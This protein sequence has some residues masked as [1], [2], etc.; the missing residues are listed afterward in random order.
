MTFK[1]FAWFETDEAVCYLNALY[2]DK[3]YCRSTSHKSSIFANFL[4]AHRKTQSLPCN[5]E[6]IRSSSS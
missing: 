2:N 4:A 1:P 5:A 6:L 3:H